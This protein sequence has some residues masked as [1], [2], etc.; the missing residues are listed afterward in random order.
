MQINESKISAPTSNKEQNGYRITRRT[1]GSTVHRNRYISMVP[2]TVTVGFLKGNGC[3]QSRS[4][5]LTYRAT[6]VPQ[7]V[8][9]PTV[10]TDRPR[11]HLRV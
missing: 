2:T 6:S 8:P 10:P 7:R 1:Q 5:S 11:S 9:Y 3:V 4:V